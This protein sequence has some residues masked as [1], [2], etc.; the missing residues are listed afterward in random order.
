MR[1]TASEDAASNREGSGIPGRDGRLRARCSSLIVVAIGFELTRQSM[2][3]I[4]SSGSTS[5]APRSGIRSRASSARCR[6]SG[7]RCIRRF[8]RSSSPRRS[9]S[10][11]RSS[12]PSC[13]RRVLRQPLVFLTELLAAIPSIV[14]GLWGIFVLV[15]AVRALETS[16]PDSRCGSCRSSPVRRSALGMLSAALIL[17]IMVI[18]FTSSVAREVLKSVP[19][20]SAKA[21]TRSAR[22]ASKRSAPRSSTRAPASSAPSCSGSAARSARRWP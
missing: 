7:A 22:R 13:A 16:L 18:P 9:R 19:A 5:G 4:R 15:P 1:G 2:L 17:A 10:A 11:S 3:S 8:S 6:S 12:S 21:R 14:Y 20:R